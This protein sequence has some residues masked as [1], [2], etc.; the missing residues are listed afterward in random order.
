MISF[1]N[2]RLEKMNE[3]QIKMANI[4]YIKKIYEQRNL[5][6]TKKR[7]NK[8]VVNENSVL[9]NYILYVYGK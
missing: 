6:N 3:Q 7:M 1:Q 5:A 2:K 9:Q 8:P 4:L